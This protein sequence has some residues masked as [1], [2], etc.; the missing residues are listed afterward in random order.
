[1]ARQHC[2]EHPPA[3]LAVVGAAWTAGGRINAGASRNRQA[4]FMQSPY[5]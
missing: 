2:C 3:A 4:N 5:G 1:M